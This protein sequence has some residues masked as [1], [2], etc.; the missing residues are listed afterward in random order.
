[1]KKSYAS[2]VNSRV[3]IN[4]GFLFVTQLIN[5]IF[6][7]I[8]LKY[9]LVTIG[10][11]YFGKV[12]FA[13]AF[14]GYFV[15]LVDFG[16]N[17]SATKAIAL[18]KNSSRAVAHTFY[19]ICF[20]KL[21]LMLLSFFIFMICIW[22]FSPFAGDNFFYT[23][24]F[25]VI[26]GLVFFPQWFF[27]GIEKMGYI[28]IVNALI[29]ISFL[30]VM[31]I[32]IKNKN[33]YLYLPILYSFSYILPGIYAF[34]IASKR[35]G[36]L[37]IPTVKEVLN[38]ISDGFNVFVSVAMSASLS[39]SAVFILG[40]L[41]NESTVGYYAGYDRLARAASML[42]YPIT[43]A[44]YPEVTRR[45]AQSHSLGYLYL[46]KIALPTISLAVVL[47]ISLI[48]FSGFLTK[49]LYQPGF[50]AYRVVLYILSGWFVMNLI[51][52]FIG[53]Q[54]LTATG[55]S[56][57]YAKSCAITAVVSII[58][59]YLFTLKYS[60]I[61]TAVSVLLSEIILACLMLFFIALERSRKKQEHD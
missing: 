19:T 49:Y 39:G 46:K 4:A 26:I 57:I 37:I 11:A 53:V 13:L 41:S 56:K 45:F 15:L 12:S 42:F 2:L 43:L 27:Q 52:N 54:Y 44:I 61:G 38:A 34:W 29:K 50:L 22:Q 35:V 18:G 23:S 55:R 9:L 24:F 6:P 36:P 30:L 16:F 7:I 25:G 21:L 8:T 10:V 1:M 48:F 40:L 33:D 17:V 60:Y 32:V 58:I 59:L 3:A 47:S 20:A 14:I 28:T 51:N 5:F 31:V